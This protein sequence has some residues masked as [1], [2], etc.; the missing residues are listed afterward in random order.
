MRTIGATMVGLILVACGSQ[1]SADGQHAGAGSAAAPESVAIAP[2]TGD[3]LYVVNGGD[4]TVAV[5]D[6]TSG[7]LLGKI[8]LKNVSYPHHVY[9]SPDCGNRTIVNARIGAS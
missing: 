7:T 2:I 6:P 5:L 9:L 8:Q 1:H 4:S 3:A